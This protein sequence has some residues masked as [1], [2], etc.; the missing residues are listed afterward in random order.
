MNTQHRSV[1]SRGRSLLSGLAA[2]AIATSTL[3]AGADPLTPTSDGSGGTGGVFGEAAD[4]AGGVDPGPTGAFTYGIPIDL[5]RARGLSQ[6]HLSVGYSSSSGDGELGAGWSLATSRIERRPLSGAPSFIDQPLPHAD[7]FE[8]NGE[9]LVYVCTVGAGGCAV[10]GA[11]DATAPSFAQGARYYRLQADTIY[12]RFFQLSSTSWRVQFRGGLLVDFGDSQIAATL[13]P[14]GAAL[15]VDAATGVPLRF[16]VSRAQDPEPYGSAGNIVVYRWDHF[17]RTGRGYLTDIWDTPP[18]SSGVSAPST[19]FAHHT[20][21]VYENADT[22]L[23]T[24]AQIEHALRDYRLSRITVSSAPWTVWH[25]TFRTVLRQYKFLYKLPRTSIPSALVGE[26]PAWG[27]SYL[28]SATEYGECDSPVAEGPTENPPET[29]CSR[30]MP[31]VTFDYSSPDLIMGPTVTGAPMLGMP[32][33]HYDRQNKLLEGN[34]FTPAPVPFGDGYGYLGTYLSNPDQYHDVEGLAGAFMDVDHDGRPD[35]VDMFSDGDQ[36]LF[37]EGAPA[38]WNFRGFRKGNVWLNRADPAAQTQFQHACADNQAFLGPLGISLGGWMGNGGPATLVGAWG[39]SRFFSAVQGGGAPGSYGFGV[40]GG[41]GGGNPSE[42]CDQFAGDPAHPLFQWTTGNA[43]WSPPPDLPPRPGAWYSDVDGDG[44]LDMFTGASGCSGFACAEVARFQPANVLS[45]T[46]FSKVD[47]GVDTPIVR[48]FYADPAKLVDVTSPG[49]IA[50]AGAPDAGDRFSYVDVTGDGI[51]DLVWYHHDDGASSVPIVRP[52][53][54]RGNFACSPGANPPT[55]GGPACAKDGADPAWVSSGYPISVVGGAPT[56]WD[57]NHPKPYVTYFHDVTGDGLADIVSYD[58]GGPAYWTKDPLDVE[59]HYVWNGDGF[60]RLWVNLDGRRFQCAAPVGDCVVGKIKNAVGMA[61]DVRLDYAKVSFAD[62]D[63]NGV[64]DLV[65]AHFSGL[66]VFPFVQTPARGADSRAPKP[67]L[68]TRIDNGR[69]AITRVSY[70][71]VQ[72]LDADAQALQKP[73]STHLPVVVPVVER[74]SVIDSATLLATPTPLPATF[75]RASSIVYRDPAYDPWT[76]R[77]EGFRS[78]TR[79]ISG[80]SDVVTTSYWYSACLQDVTPDSPLCLA[81]SDDDPYRPFAGFPVRI[82]HYVPAV[83]E[84]GFDGQWLSSVSSTVLDHQA[85]RPLITLPDP[86]D[87]RWVRDAGQSTWRQEIVYDATLATGGVYGQILPDGQTDP[88]GPA[89]QSAAKVLHTLTTRDPNGTVTQVD[90]YA[91]SGLYN[92]LL[93]AVVQRTRQF[94]APMDSSWIGAVTAISTTLPN[95]DSHLRDVDATRVVNIQN[96]GP[97]P[98][99]V[100]TYYAGGVALNRAQSNGTPSPLPNRSTVILALMQHDELGNLTSTSEAGIANARQ[101]VFNEKYKQYPSQVQDRLPN[102]TY[103]A[104]TMLSYHRGFAKVVLATD[105]DRM[106]ASLVHLDGFGRTVA[107]WEGNGDGS[108]S[109]FFPTGV[110]DYSDIGPAPWRHAVLYADGAWQVGINVQNGL[111]EAIANIGNANP[112]D[113]GGWIVS[114][115]TW[116]TSDGK[117]AA[118]TRP[119]FLTVGDPLADLSGGTLSLNPVASLGQR[120]FTRDTFGRVVKTSEAGNVLGDIEYHPLRVRY[121]DANEYAASPGSIAGRYQ[122]DTYDRFGDLA[123]HDKAETIERMTVQYVRNVAGQPV[124]SLHTHSG[125]ADSVS[126]TVYFDSLGHMVQN[127]RI[128]RS[129]GGSTDS[130]LS[131]SWRYTWDGFRL[132]GTS[133]PR[134]CGNNLSYDAIGR[135]LAEDYSPCTADQPLYTVPDL[136]TGDGTEV[137][138]RYDSYEPDQV[139]PEPGF[140]ED[141]PRFAV[142]QLVSLRDRAV[143]DTLNY[144]GRGRVRRSTRQ[145]ARPDMSSSLLSERYTARKYDVM[146]EFD[147]VNRPTLN[148]ARPYEPH[149]TNNGEVDGGVIYD[150]RGFIRTTASSLGNIVAAADYEADGLPRSIVYGDVAATQASFSYDSMRSLNHYTLGRGAPATWSASPSPNTYSL[151]D[152][153]TTQTQLVDETISND[154]LGNPSFIMDASLGTQWPSSIRPVQLKSFTYDDSYRLTDVQIQ[155]SG[156]L[157]TTDPYTSPNAA[158]GASSRPMPL[159][160]SPNR[161]THQSFAYDWRGN[162]TVSRDDSR[163]FFDRNIGTPSYDAVEADRLVGAVSDK[164]EPLSALYDAAGNL[165]DLQVERSGD[166]DGNGTCSQRFLYTWDEVGQLATATRYDYSGAIPVEERQP[167]A[168]QIGA[169]VTMSYAYSGGVRVR[170]SV[171]DAGGDSAHALELSSMQRVEH[172]DFDADLGDYKFSSVSTYVAGGGRVI[173]GQSYPAAAGDLFSH[174]FIDMGDHLGSTS[175]VIDSASSEVVEKTTYGAY[176][177]VEADYR[178]ERWHEFREA[179][180][181]TGKEDDRE[182][183]LTY[184]GARYYSPFLQRFVSQDPLTVHGMAGDPN[185]FA[186]V[187]GRVT[188]WTDPLGLDGDGGKG[189]NGLPDNPPDWVG[190]E[191]HGDKVY[192]QTGPNQLEETDADMKARVAVGAEAGLKSLH[193][194]ASHEPTIALV[195]PIARLAL[196]PDARVDLGKINDAAA[197]TIINNVTPIFSKKMTVGN[198]PNSKAGAGIG[199]GLLG[200]AMAAAGALA[201]AA[202]VTRSLI[203]TDL[204][205]AAN[206]PMRA[207]NGT[208]TNAGSTRVIKVVYIEAA[209]KGSLL[210]QL[211]NALPNILAAARASGVKTLQIEATF[212]NPALEAFMKA[213]TEAHGGIYSSAAGVDMMT[214]ILP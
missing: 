162:T 25:S 50:P 214:F 67:G 169:S 177:Q 131:G 175:V 146:S 187:Q 69:G 24:N 15:D 1:S 3:R 79:Q 117:V 185:P 209:T 205:L 17:G 144:D 160:T 120:D 129:A 77:F 192:T 39:A 200:L 208:V 28:A 135:V 97:Y 127:G 197:K 180:K 13:T 171:M 105:M 22:T 49:Q 115:E 7:R 182:V 71:T 93:S 46:R 51:D 81:T 44:L 126:R 42:F 136:A 100:Y 109:D 2:L 52:G 172:A 151:P 104:G 118:I 36:T 101:F 148:Y 58:A 88:N 143:H 38:Y 85:G 59:S 150:S 33:V 96:A 55:D 106:E 121:R 170:K 31:M 199:N 89:S 125:G 137:F 61:G 211:R 212:A 130:D 83:P 114:G 132:T 29:Q 34:G 167:S 184:F 27:H 196:D 11:T 123:Q 147:N 142:G 174:M 75:D 189:T 32:P 4:N 113:P 139:A 156:A 157:D 204:G 8:F 134:G 111:G 178:P 164:D 84:Q 207:M 20:K 76:H 66:Y 191:I 43:P 62:M 161:M 149:L 124:F 159:Q 110:M 72:E 158:E 103:T 198:D 166:C 41:A 176:G 26:A 155:Y 190:P 30:A 48:P 183:G 210:P 173:I 73:W 9:P 188:S 141:D 153:S 65:V 90:E 116:R 203:A 133:D 201:E 152:W 45:T 10:D 98:E 18:A 74:V 154:V 78:V 94:T 19:D 86:H 82:D 102:G 68:L 6:P 70:A 40:V 80:R 193:D 128:S 195:E 53:D 14:L 60:V 145:H 57:F 91:P 168:P 206:T 35:Y 56:P 64:D 23:G 47:S 87:G 186:Y 54:G 138:Y 5:P 37:N 92:S 99:A 194:S 179:F 140:A 12:A 122:E 95:P 202:P 165:V 21:L 163:L 119:W 16:N 108:L 112:T 181:F 213:A 63:A 107:T